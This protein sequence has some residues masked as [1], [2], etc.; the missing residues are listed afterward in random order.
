MDVSAVAFVSDTGPEK[1]NPYD[2]M[3]FYVGKGS[4]GLGL[5]RI[6]NI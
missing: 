6:L 3:M 1:G 4:G 2:E 5:G